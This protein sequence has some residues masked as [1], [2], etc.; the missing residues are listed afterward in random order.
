MENALTVHVLMRAS[1]KT[2]KID[3]T[4]TSLGKAQLVMWALTNTTR[5]KQSFIFERESGKVMAIVTGSDTG[6]PTM[7]SADHK[8]LG[9]CEDYNIPLEELHK[10]LDDRFDKEEAAI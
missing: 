10:I 7:S 1:K 6:M 2:G 8:D 9:I 3:T 4:L 5:G